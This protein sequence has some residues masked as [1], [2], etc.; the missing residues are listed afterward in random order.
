LH[1]DLRGCK[2]DVGNEGNAVKV[3]NLNFYIWILLI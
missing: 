1:T 2:H 3:C